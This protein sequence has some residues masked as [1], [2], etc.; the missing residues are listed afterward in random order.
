MPQRMS[1]QELMDQVLRFSAEAMT[2]YATDSVLY[3]DPRAP[4]RFIQVYCAIALMRIGFRVV[5]EMNRSQFEALMGN[6]IPAEPDRRRFGLDLVIFDPIDRDNA[7]LA[8][9]RAIVEYKRDLYRPGSDVERTARFLGELGGAV[10]MFVACQSYFNSNFPQQDI[11]AA[12]MA[13]DGKT[14]SFREL[15]PV[16]FGKNKTLF[17]VAVG[18]LVSPGEVVS[19]A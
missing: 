5:V 10:G 19:A 2:F 13:F 8:T 15:E 14:L 3:D 17:G 9:P 11:E 18:V 1:D 12:R 4:E 6:S 16:I 7:H